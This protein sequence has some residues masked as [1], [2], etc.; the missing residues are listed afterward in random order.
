MIACWAGIQVLLNQE[1]TLLKEKS[2]AKI[3]ND[4]LD[5]T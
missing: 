5:A 4:A 3:E 2:K 1:L